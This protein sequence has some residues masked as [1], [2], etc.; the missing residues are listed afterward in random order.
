MVKIPISRQEALELVKKYNSDSR[1]L[2]HYL[3]SEAIMREVASKLGEDT[4]YWGI[5]GLLHDI[6]WGLTKDN[7]SNHLTKAPQ[8]LKDAGF[9]DE[10]VSIVLSHGYGY[11]ELPHLKDKKRIRKIEYALAASETLTGLIH[12][13]ALM[14]GSKVSDMELAGLKKKF[15]DKAFAAGCDRNI[16]KEAENFMN[17]DEF[18]ACGIEG[19]KKIK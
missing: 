18:L 2:I 6:D 1:D 7:V 5:L 13:Y 15:K 3:E 12:A 9:D 4:E 8:L 10:F 16:I 11:E 14:R 19:I 17:F